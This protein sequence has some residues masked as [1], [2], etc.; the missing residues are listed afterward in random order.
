MRIDSCGIKYGK[1]C[2]VSEGVIFNA[3]IILSILRINAK[4]LEYLNNVR[5][6]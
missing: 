6:A 1:L 2:I 5:L 4:S 3:Y